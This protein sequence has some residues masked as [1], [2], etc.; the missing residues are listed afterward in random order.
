MILF[1]SVSC[2]FFIGRPSAIIWRVVTVVV[3]AFYCVGM[4][5]FIWFR[6]HVGNKLFKAKPTLADLNVPRAIEVI[7]VIFR[8][9]A[10]SNHR[11]PSPIDTCI[12]QSVSCITFD[13]GNRSFMS[14]A[15]AR[16]SVA[17]AY[18]V[19]IGYNLLTAI[20]LEFPMSFPGA[21]AMA[22]T[23]RGQSSISSANFHCG[24]LS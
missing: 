15:S 14:Q 12:S 13:C 7:T 23:K 1:S 4:R 17:Y 8:I 6:P 11:T 9:S 24:R 16:T 21:V 3:D 5:R 2:L 10:S 18:I 19:A 22:E 20:T